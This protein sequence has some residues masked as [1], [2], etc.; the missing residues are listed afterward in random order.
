MNIAIEFYIFELVQA[1]NFKINWQFF[2]WTKF[3]QKGY[4]QPKRDQMKHAI[5]FYVFELVL[6][7]NFS[8]NGQFWFFLTKFAQ[9]WYLRSKSRK[10]NITTEFFIFKLEESNYIFLAGGD[11]LVYLAEPMHKKC[12]TIF[13]SGYPF[14]A[15]ISYDWC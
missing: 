12:S 14:S 3:A 5:K 8:L 7:P 13:V 15:Y 11:A 4:F 10:V 9:K 2:F 6:V 1:Q